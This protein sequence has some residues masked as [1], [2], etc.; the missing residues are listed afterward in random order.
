MRE[1]GLGALGAEI[2][3]RP[4]L[5]DAEEGLIGPAVGVLAPPRP[6]RSC[7]GRR[8]RSSLRD[9]GNG[10]QW[11]RHI[12]T[13]APRASWMAVAR[14]GVSSSRLPSMC[15]R[16]V[17]PVVGHAAARRQAEDLEAARVGQDRAV[18]AHETSA[19]RPAAATTSSPG[20][21]AR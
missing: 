17:T 1:Q 5:D 2:G 20:R 7:G 6:R 12:A 18:P 8:R 3:V 11:S 19:G 10:G 13:S 15:E 16:N 4:A 14:S 21:R 9:A